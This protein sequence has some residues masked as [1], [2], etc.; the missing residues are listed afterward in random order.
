MTLA[1]MNDVYIEGSCGIEGVVGLDV[2]VGCYP[3]MSLYS[4]G[5]GRRPAHC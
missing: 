1:K 2:D 3:S 5:K 4:G